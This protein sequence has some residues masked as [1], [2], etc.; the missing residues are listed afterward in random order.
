M[1][2]KKTAKLNLP[3]GKVIELPVMSGSL[4]PDVIDIT[5]LYKQADMFT[6]D[7][8]FT[9]TGSCKSDITFI[10]GDQGILLHRGYKIE[11]LAE[12]SSF[13]ETSYLLMYGELPSKEKKLE[14]VNSITM[15]TMLNEQISNFYRGF[16]DNAHPMAILCGVVGAMAAFYHDSTDINNADERK[17]ASYR[18][19]AKMPT[20]AAM[21]YKFSIGQPFVYPNNSLNYSENFL[22]M[23]FSVPAE[24]Y[25]INPIFADA[26]DK[27][28]ILH[29]DHEQNASTSTV[30]LAGSS[31]ANPFA[32]IAAGI[33]SLW[34][35]AHGG[36]NEAV[37]KMLNEIESIENIKKFIDKA[38]DRND[39]FRLMGFGHRVYK[40]YD[41][42]AR[43]LQKIAE[44]VLKEKHLLDNKLFDLAKELEYL[45]LNDD[46]F[47]EK[48][49]YPNVDFYS[50]IILK[51]IGF[52]VSL[53]TVIF[54]V[55]RTVGWIS[56]WNEMISDQNS[57]IGR[58]RQL[59]TG[60]PQR[61]FS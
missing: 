31:G 36:A 41:P 7:P 47:K 27:I 57:K 55:A 22:N 6:F 53:F 3:N 8:G 49:L 59:Y 42:R 33:A 24:K 19:I 39:S 34:G 11:D 30:R 1:N 13:L 40:N 50:G 4:G 25:E 61:E 9:S 46:Y 20:I 14:F 21:A 51:A 52:P 2:N 32:C 58:P 5:S 37:I 16:K 18:L 26:L 54:A 17:I 60:K 56:H 43:V 45:A 35:P 44:K 38:K 28:L 23:V 10:D 15:H 48:K 29:A 12:K